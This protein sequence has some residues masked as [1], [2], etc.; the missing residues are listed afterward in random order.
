MAL[1]GET[2]RH[3]EVTKIHNVTKSDIIGITTVTVSNFGD[4]ASED[5]ATTI[6]VQ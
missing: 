2:T 4:S 5:D 3:T 6:T 1:V